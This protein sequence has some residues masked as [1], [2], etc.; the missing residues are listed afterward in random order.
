MN[1]LI[2]LLNRFVWQEVPL[3]LYAM[4]ERFEKMKERRAM[5]RSSYSGGGGRRGGGRG[6]GRGFRRGGNRSG[7]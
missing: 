5:E 1:I 3:E 6:G 2:F 7:W 4:A